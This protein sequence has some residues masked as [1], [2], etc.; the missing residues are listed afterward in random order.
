MISL[1]R[2][3]HN[4][5][6]RP[7][8]M[9]RLLRLCEPGQPFAPGPACH[10]FGMEAGHPVLLKY[11]PGDGSEAGCQIRLGLDVKA[12]DEADTL[13]FEV[14]PG[15]RSGELGHLS[16][17]GKVRMSSALLS[18]VPRPH[19]HGGNTA[20]F[21]SMPCGMM[22]V[23]SESRPE[24]RTGAAEN[25]DEGGAARCCCLRFLGRQYLPAAANTT[26]GNGASADD[27]RGQKGEVTADLEQQRADAD[28][29]AADLERRLA[30]AEQRTAASPTPPKAELAEPNPT[31][32]PPPPEPEPVPKIAPTSQNIQR[33][34]E[35]VNGAAVG[36][37]ELDISCVVF[38]MNEWSKNWSANHRPNSDEVKK[39]SVKLL[40][41]T[42][43][44]N[45]I[46][47]LPQYASI[48][49]ALKVLDLSGCSGISGTFR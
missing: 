34:I 14:S 37:L 48:L 29:R 42:G 31:P 49:V 35:V 4:K 38:A 2:G 13:V 24:E 39:A 30:E 27:N 25:N 43:D 1:E 18:A 10:A 16:F 9:K 45:S 6:L 44:R 15:A 11:A 19:Q 36:E 20:G 28:R 47:N 23:E 26:A 8:E 41:L 3:T 32:P 7:D 22:H 40:E 33:G 46:S 17:R 21:A 5:K 12:G